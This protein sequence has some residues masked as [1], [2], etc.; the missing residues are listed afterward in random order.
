M[1]AKIVALIAHELLDPIIAEYRKLGPARRS[2]QRFA[3]RRAVVR[4][5]GGRAGTGMGSRHPAAG[6]REGGRVRPPGWCII[7]TVTDETPHEHADHSHPNGTA[8]RQTAGTLI[9]KAAGKAVAAELGP[10]IAGLLPQLMQIVPQLVAQGLAQALQQVPVRTTGR[11]CA[12]CLAARIT[13]EVTHKA[14]MDA[15]REAAMMTAGIEDPKDPRLGQLDATPYLPE[16]LRA[17]SGTAEQMPLILDAVTI[18]AGDEVC[19]MHL[20]GLPQRQLNA[21]PILIPRPQILIAPPGMSPELAARLA[22][23]AA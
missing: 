2:R 9:G 6:Y 16:H 23:Q 4:Q 7:S 19:H 21:P 13:W 5:R 12:K 10:A 14:E 17:G 20:P 22:S 11:M 3:A 8:F 1:L 15:A 18:A